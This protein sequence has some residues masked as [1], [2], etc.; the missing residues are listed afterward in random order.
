MKY[1][2]KIYPMID[3]SLIDRDGLRKVQLEMFKSFVSICE[4]YHLRY[5]AAEGTVLGA[6]R[7]QGYIPWDDDIDVCM[8][9]KDYDIFLSV[10]QKELPE[11]YF[12]QTYMT[13]P[14]FRET[15]A[16]IRNSNTTFL[17]T[18]G[19]K[20]NINHGAWID[21]FPVDG[22][23]NSNCKVN[24]L[25]FFRKLV[26]GYLGKDYYPRTFARR[27]AA[28]VCQVLLLAKNTQKLL[29]RLEKKY[30]KYPFDECER[31][32]SYGAAYEKKEIHKRETYGEG[33][34]VKFENTTIRVPIDADT[35]LRET[36]GDYMKLPPKEQQVGRHNCSICD[37]HK[38]YKEYR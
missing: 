33:K 17:E 32:I 15:L 29:I 37:L 12:L 9:R 20:I 38:S 35:Y 8:P 3:D 18:Y 2:G 7:H 1:K 34:I 21:I 26:R 13:D 23:P 11:E 4:K 10:A 28:R 36:Y 31:T 25:L 24:R 19:Q 16:K 6:I 27:V 30:K 22:I 14:D 5:Y